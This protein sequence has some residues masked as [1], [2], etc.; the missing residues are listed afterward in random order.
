MARA[1]TS[2]GVSGSPHDGRTVLGVVRTGCSAARRH[3]RWLRILR[4]GM[5]V[6]GRQVVDQG[7]VTIKR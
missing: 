4:D 1:P 6:D 3:D 5:V 2:C 7:L